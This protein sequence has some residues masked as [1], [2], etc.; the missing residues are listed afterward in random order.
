MC[1]KVENQRFLSV[2][3][4]KCRERERER[5]RER[6]LPGKDALWPQNSCLFKFDMGEDVLSI[7]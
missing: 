6:K 3:G 1:R 4:E 7:L 2:L 5:E